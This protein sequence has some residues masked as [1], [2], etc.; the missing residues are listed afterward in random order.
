MV[1]MAD[2][3]MDTGLGGAYYP[4]YEAGVGGSDRLSLYDS[5]FKALQATGG[6]PRAGTGINAAEVEDLSGT[7]ASAEIKEK[8]LHFWKRVPKKPAKS[9]NAEWVRIDDYGDEGE[10]GFIGGTDAGFVGDPRF[11]RGNKLIKYL[12]VKG[13]VDLPTQLVELVGFGGRGVN[14][15]NTSQTARMRHLLRL[16]ERNLFH[17][18][19]RVS[20]LEFDGMFAQ[21]DAEADEDNQCRYD[22]QGGFLDRYVL[23]HMSQ[24]AANNNADISDF[25]LPNEAY[26][27]LQQSLFPQIRTGDNI[28]DA[29]VGANFERLL[30]MSLGGNPDYCQ[31]RRTQMLTN[32]VKGALPLKVPTR[33]GR[34]APTK[35]E[36]VSG[37]NVTITATNYQPG[38]TA[39]TY[40]YSVTA[41]GK[42]GRSLATSI[43]SA[44]TA[45]EG[46]GARL[47]ITG[48]DEDILFYEVYRN[49]AGTSGLLEK[50]R[51]YMCR[52]KRV[53]A[54]TTFTDD[55]YFLPNTMHM[56]AFSFDDDEVYV[57]QLLPPVK[58]QLPQELMANSFGILVFLALVNEVPTHNIHV[59]NIGKRLQSGVPA[60]G[61]AVTG[62]A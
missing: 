13:Q 17:A 32:G 56:G 7:L 5:V 4:D 40:Y 59:V 12:A 9:L 60:V 54:S 38:L 62:S 24:N 55:G 30:I 61:E 33:A 20:D 28:P 22:L 39:G 29:A 52:V 48:S 14:A 37:T 53:G 19:S 34:N 21:I 44:V 16:I 41:V 45:A 58:R 57:K 8:T 23:I 35:P 46:E 15:M 51:K 42:G 18:D 36:A 1:T 6:L 2:Y 3:G 25:Y 26:L 49:E 10:N 47:T 50:N 31:I 11:S 43:T 27:D